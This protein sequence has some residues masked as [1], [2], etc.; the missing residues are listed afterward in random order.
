MAKSHVVSLLVFGRFFTYVSFCGSLNLGE[1][2]LA[3]SVHFVEKLFA[4]RWDS[5]NGTY[6]VWRFLK[7]FGDLHSPCHVIVVGCGPQA[8][9]VH[10]CLVAVVGFV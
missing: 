2:F 5:G 1:E 6:E 9:F 3:S 8:D 10:P 4:Q 7:T